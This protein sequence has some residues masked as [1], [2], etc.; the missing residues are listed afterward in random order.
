MSLSFAVLVLDG[1]EY[2][3][4]SWTLGRIS[5]ITLDG[6]IKLP[7][8][9]KSVIVASKFGSHELSKKMIEKLRAHS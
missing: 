6:P 1:L 5:H 2:P 4:N 9:M 3:V 8:V 7:V